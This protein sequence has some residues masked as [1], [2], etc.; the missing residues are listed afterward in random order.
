MC[1]TLHDFKFLGT[2]LT[3]VV[4]LQAMLE[5]RYTF[6]PNTLKYK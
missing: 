4:Y 5:E 3:Q 1:P 2:A 6:R